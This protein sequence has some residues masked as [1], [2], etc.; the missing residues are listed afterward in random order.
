MEINKSKME[1]DS[2]QKQYDELKSPSMENDSNLNGTFNQLV[3]NRIVYNFIS[4]KFEIKTCTDETELLELK[5]ATPNPK[6]KSV[7]LMIC[8]GIIEEW[9]HLVEKSFGS[10][11]D[12]FG[13]DTNNCGLLHLITKGA[14][15]WMVNIGNEDNFH[16]LIDSVIAEAKK[17]NVNIS[18][19]CA[20]FGIRKQ[21]DE[22]QLELFE[23][24]F[25]KLQE[26]FP[27][28]KTF[29][30]AG[31]PSER[32]WPSK[33]LKFGKLVTCISQNEPFHK[34]NPVL[35]FDEIHRQNE[36]QE[37]GENLGSI[38]NVE[39]F[40]SRSKVTIT[41]NKR[42]NPSIA[43]TV[44]AAKHYFKTELENGADFGQW[45]KSNLKP[46]NQNLN[47]SSWRMGCFIS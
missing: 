42:G 6:L 46:I 31:I 7:V 39:D 33:F 24:L 21:I 22:K 29:I 28:S 3:Y 16:P 20:P 26:N 41:C 15:I 35:Y 30:A 18:T 2:V 14:R 23:S 12:I 19:I 10:Y 40:K 8:C 36:F 37:V 11:A 27:T 44:A 17:E 25:E 43:A 13:V 47:S 45:E 32:I 5:N 38:Y 34:I 9:S 4:E 1:D